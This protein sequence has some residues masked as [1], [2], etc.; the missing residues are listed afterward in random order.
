MMDDERDDRAIHAHTSLTRRRV[1]RAATGSFALAASGLFLPAELGE[2]EAREGALGGDKGGRH[3]K[4]HKG[5]HRHRTH[6][7]KK[8]KGK[9]NRPPGSGSG[10]W[11]LVR[12]VAV[13]TAYLWS[14]PGVSVDFYF[15]V[16]R[17]LDNWGPLVFAKTAEIYPGNVDYAPERYSIVAFFHGPALPSTIYV[18]MRNGLFITPWAKV[19]AGCSIDGNGNIVGGTTLAS[20]D[21]E[22]PVDNIDFSKYIKASIGKGI[23]GRDMSIKVQRLVNSDT[24]VWFYAMIG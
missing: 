3:G 16:K 21:L 7:N 1:L 2:T 13:R 23:Y 12:Y 5:Q 24:Q 4:N 15:R 9:A 19:I 17:D 11:S 20:G 10:K 22:E 8:N 6:G 14:E 18:E